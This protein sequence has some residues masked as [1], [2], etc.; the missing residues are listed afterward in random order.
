MTYTAALSAATIP[1]NVVDS[2]AGSIPVTRVN[3]TL[4]GLT[5]EWSDPKVGTGHGSPVVER[6]LYGGENA[7]YDAKKMAGLPIGVQIVGKRWEEEKV[8]EMMK[9]IDRALGE[10]EFGPGCWGDTK[11]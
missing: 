9:V 7:F 6:Y 1:F 3:P 10:R 8:V 4:D 5:P 11:F 2:P